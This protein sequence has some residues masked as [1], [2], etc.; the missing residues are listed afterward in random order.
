MFAR[1]VSSCLL[2]YL[3]VSYRP[4]CLH[5]CSYRIVLFACIF[6]RIASSCLPTYLLICSYGIAS[7]F[8]LVSYRLVCTPMFARI[9]SSWLISH[10]WPYFVLLLLAH[11]A[12]LFRTV[13]WPNFHNFYLRAFRY[14][15]LVPAPP[16]P[17]LTQYLLL[18][19]LKAFRYMSYLSELIGTCCWSLSPP[20]LT[21]F[22][23]HLSL[24]T[25]RYMLLVPVP[26]LTNP[27]FITL[28][29]QNL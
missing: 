12:A 23:L 18:L 14:M 9:V 11:V 10:V 8:L 22:S 26:P 1:I 20:R 4:V 13:D 28:I 29:S 16:P 27:I 7:S 6:A 24:R 19:S 21:Q 5:I 3:L 25:Y 17:R 2:A 15:L